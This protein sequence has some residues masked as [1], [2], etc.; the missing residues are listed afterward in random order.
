MAKCCNDNLSKIFCNTYNK[1][2][3]TLYANGE[4]SK[5]ETENLLVISYIRKLFINPR[6]I[7]Y[8][9]I[10]IKALRCI[11]DRSCLLDSSELYG[12]LD[13]KTVG[14]K[15]VTIQ[16]RD[17]YSV[18]IEETD[19]T[20]PQYVKDIKQS[21]ITNWNNKLSQETDPVFSASPAATITDEDINNWNNPSTSGGQFVINVEYHS[22]AQEPYTIDK[23]WDE[24]IGA[25][26]NNQTLVLN[27]NNTIYQLQAIQLSDNY[28][29]FGLISSTDIDG[30][31]FEISTDGHG[32]FCTYLGNINLQQ[33]LISGTNIKTI[34]NSSI[35]SSGNIDL[36]PTS[37]FNSFCPIIEDT[38]SSA[39]TNITGVAPFSTL[40]NG[41]RIMLFLANYYNVSNPTLTLTL[42]GGGQT[43][44]IPIYAQTAGS[45]TRPQAA[46]MAAGAYFEMVYISSS[47]RWQVVGKDTNTTYITLSQATINAGTEASSRVITAALL[48]D[49]AYI[50][51]ESYSSGSLKA[52]KMYDFG[53]VSSALTIP[54]LDVTNDLVSNAL[55]FY[56]LRFIAGADNISIT[57][58]TGV[59]VDDEPTINTGDYVEIM[60]NLYVENNTNHFYAS[61]KVWQAQQQNS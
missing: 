17:I 30:N 52:N 61:I 38:R 1:Y 12:R 5:K 57:F 15:F 11:A 25:Y 16:M 8:R 48:H 51:E 7:N 44:A 29:N 24:I 14:D 35:L 49:N 50:V 58:P 56:A 54:T 43:S 10:L 2:Y 39:V 33:E 31:T 22:G 55:N 18:K 34:N 19:P 4:I 26:Q 59:I 28:I 46:T 32:T 20:V 3:N 42:S 60:I 21:D 37:T 40:M 47:D 27:F 53:T 41:Q 45:N 6:Y 23:E 13:I 9:P 36:V